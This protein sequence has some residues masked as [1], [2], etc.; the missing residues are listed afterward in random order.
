MADEKPVNYIKLLREI[1]DEI[2]R[3]IAEMS[4]EEQRPLERA[5][6]RDAGEQGARSE[7]GTQRG[8]AAE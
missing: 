8:L 5:A 6:A 2:N 4:F 3:E 7:P 1:R